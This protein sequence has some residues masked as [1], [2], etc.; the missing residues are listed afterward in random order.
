M[1][2]FA[3]ES[4]PQAQMLESGLAAMRDQLAKIES[5]AQSAG[6]PA[7]PVRGLPEAG[8]EYARRLRDVKYHETLFELLSKQYEAARIDEARLAPVIQVVDEAVPPDKKSWPPRLLFVLGAGA[9]AAFAVSL[10]VLRQNRP[11]SGTA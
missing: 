8:L 10:L 3:A 4:N 6:S 11:V 5:G 1:R 7:M 2:L 9:L